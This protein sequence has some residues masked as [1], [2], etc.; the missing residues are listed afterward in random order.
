MI[1]F[2]SYRTNYNKMG[3]KIPECFVP[4]NVYEFEKEIRKEFPKLDRDDPPDSIGV[5]KLDAHEL[6]YIRTESKQRIFPEK[7]QRFLLG[8]CDKKFGAWLFNIGS[9]RFWVHHKD[10]SQA[11]EYLRNNNRKTVKLNGN[12]YL[13]GFVC[14]ITDD[15]VG[16]F[17]ENLRDAEKVEN[18][19]RLQE[20]LYN[21]MSL[22]PLLLKPVPLP[23]NLWNSDFRLN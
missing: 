16:Q 9:K 6:G 21:P 8:I 10:F 15:L 14:F 19:K 7:T 3:N 23:P 11:E 18:D 17:M 12:I 1:L 4:Y 22:Y 13:N 20:L 5:R 2:I